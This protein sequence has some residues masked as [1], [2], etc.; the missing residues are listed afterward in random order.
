[1]RFKELKK[2]VKKVCNTI[3]SIA[4]FGS[5]TSDFKKSKAMNRLNVLEKYT[6][7][8]AKSSNG[9]STLRWRRHMK[10][11]GLSKRQMSTLKELS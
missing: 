2:S 8:S 5:S 1:M 11:L 3:L 4:H 6:Q 10:D 7:T 9:R